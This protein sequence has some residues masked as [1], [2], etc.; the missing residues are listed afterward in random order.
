M[1]G[2]YCFALKNGPLRLKHSWRHLFSDLSDFALQ[3]DKTLQVL[4]VM[5]VL[6][7]IVTPIEHALKNCRMQS[8]CNV[9]QLDCYILHISLLRG[10]EGGWGWGGGSAQEMKEEQNMHLVSFFCSV[11]FVTWKGNQRCGQ[12]VLCCDDGGL[13]MTEP[14]MC[15]HR[16]G[17]MECGPRQLI[18]FSSEAVM[19]RVYIWRPGEGGF[20]LQ[21][22]IKEQTLL[23]EGA[24]SVMLNPSPVL[25]NPSSARE[26]VL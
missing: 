17:H 5:I 8:I 9:N 11:Y 4:W 3:T 12:K 15:D 1:C 13:P 18:V 24:R 21:V 19:Q 14:V 16:L 10:R 20:V 2:C 25:F 6:L 7:F 23:T 22:L 26:F